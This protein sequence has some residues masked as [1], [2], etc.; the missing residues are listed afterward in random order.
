ML[1]A[2]VPAL[3]LELLATYPAVATKG[4]LKRCSKYI[5]QQQ[6]RR[7]PKGHAGSKGSR[8][9]HDDKDLPSRRSL[10]RCMVG[11]LGSPTLR[12]S[13]SRVGNRSSSTSSLRSTSSLVRLL[14]FARTTSICSRPH[15]DPGG[16]DAR[17]QKRDP[18]EDVR[19]DA[20]DAR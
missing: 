6:P 10:P 16:Q 14:S 11:N 5:D 19:V 8:T 4:H 15:R 9:L 20:G 17:T 3:Q 18:E 13:L 12:T 2:P 1:C 7:S